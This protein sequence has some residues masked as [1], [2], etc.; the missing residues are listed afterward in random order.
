MGGGVTEAGSASQRDWLIPAVVMTGGL[1]AAAIALMPAAGYSGVPPYLAAFGGWMRLSLFGLVPVAAWQLYRLRKEGVAHPLSEMKRRFT[2]R[3]GAHLSIIAGMLLAGID[4][5]AFM[6]IK[7]ELTAV[8]PFWADPTFANLDHALFGTDPWR[9]FA[10]IDLEFHA[11]AYSFFW[12]LAIMAALVWLFASPASVGRSRAILT[13]F[14]TWSIFGPL[15]QLSFSSAGPIFYQRAGFGDRF[16]GMDAQIPEV[17]QRIAGYLWTYHEKGTFAFG[18]G[19]SAMPSLHIA[20]VT[21]IVLMARDLKSKLV[22]PA[23]IFALYIFALSV[24]LGWHYAVDGIA[25]AAGAWACHY[26]AGRYLAWRAAPM[27][28]TLMPAGHFTGR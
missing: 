20:T 10:G 22:W 8:A 19:V 4:M 17:T 16:A 9:L 12:A 18:A 3:L 25:G 15:G 21:W 11:W 6:W 24:A 5:Q 27:S 26:G 13:Y 28:G 1:L 14:A 23:A 7:P 2:D